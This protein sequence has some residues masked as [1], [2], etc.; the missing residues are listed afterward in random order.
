MVACL[1]ALAKEMGFNETVVQNYTKVKEINIFCASHPSVFD[2]TIRD[3]QFEIPS[4]VASLMLDQTTGNYLL[5]T[6]G[7]LEVILDCC[8]DYWN[9]ADLTPLD[10]AARK[11]IQDAHNNAVTNDLQCVLYSY[12]PVLPSRELAELINA[13]SGPIYFELAESKENKSRTKALIHELLHEQVFLAMTA[14]AHQPKEVFD[15]VIHFAFI[16]YWNPFRTFVISSRILNSREFDSFT[17][18]KL[19]SGKA[20]VCP[21]VKFRF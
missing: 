3:D 4:A 10:E 13:Q 12:S 18:L 16:I 6:E 1:C 20:R 21:A 5:F 14:L 8:S 19:P 2:L 9:G 7:T 15:I 17:S 11:K